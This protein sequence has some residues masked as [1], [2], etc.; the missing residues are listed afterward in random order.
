MHPLS[1]S[2]VET[3]IPGYPGICCTTSRLPTGALFFEASNDLNL[4]DH[5]IIYNVEQGSGVYN[6]DC[7]GLLIAHNLIQNCGHSAV[8]I[9][10]T[11]HR[12]RIGVCKNNRVIN[13]VIAQCPVAFDYEVMENVSD[14]NIFSSMGDDFGLSDWQAS[15]LDTHSTT[16]ELEMAIDPEDPSLAWSSQTDPVPT[17]RRDEL[18]SL[19]YFG[20]PYPGDEVTVGPFTEGWSPVCR[21]LKLAINDG[22]NR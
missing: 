10:K 19:D 13:N 16:V 14:Y 18:L 20:R 3:G 17:V 1:G 2:I 11:Q 4:I 8:R 5:N 21:Q 9:R 15:G 7:D 12:D 6:R 22:M